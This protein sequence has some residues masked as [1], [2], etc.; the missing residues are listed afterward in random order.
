MIEVA[1]GIL[2][3]SAGAEVLVSRRRADQSFANML[4]FPGG[5]LEPGESATQAL[6]RELRE[7]LDVQ[8]ISCLPFALLPAPYA[9]T[10]FLL[11]IFLVPEYANEPS[12]LEGQQIAWYPRSALRAEDFMAGNDLLVSVLSSMK[13]L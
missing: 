7:E 5:K 6:R 3:R 2:T 10:S 1:I 8:V 13:Q 11:H 12:A 9:E 4:E